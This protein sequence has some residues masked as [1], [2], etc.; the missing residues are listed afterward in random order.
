M[1]EQDLGEILRSSYDEKKFMRLA[2]DIFK[3]FEE[4]TAYLPL[5]TK[6][7]AQLEYLKQIGEVNI[8]GVRFLVTAVKFKPGEDVKSTASLQRNVVGKVIKNNGAVGSLVAYMGYGNQWK[9]ALVSLDYFIGENGKAKVSESDPKRFYYVVGQK[10]IHTP[11][12][13]LNPIV[14]PLKQASLDELK[15]TF[16]VEVLTKEFYSKISTKFHELIGGTI[17]QKGKEISIDRQIQIYDKKKNKVMEDSIIKHFGIRL[18][19][20]IIFCWFLRKQSIIPE[21]VLSSA[22]VTNDYYHK[23]LEPLFFEVMNTPNEER[24]D[25]IKKNSKLNTIPFLNGG[26][27][28]PLDVDY[29]HPN[30][31]VSIPDKWMKELF[32]ILEEYNFVVDEGSPLDQEVSVNPEM[33]GRIFENLLAEINPETSETARKSTGS[34]YT[35][36]PI[37]DYMVKQSIKYYLLSKT[38]LSEDLIDKILSDSEEEVALTKEERRVIVEA[39]YNMKVLDP[40]CGSGAFPI[41][42]LLRVVSTLRKV[43]NQNRWKELLIKDMQDEEEIQHIDTKSDDYVRKY[44]ILKRCIYGVD[45]QPMAVELSKLRS[46]LTLIIEEKD[47]DDIKPLPNLDFKF[48]CANTLIGL[49]KEKSSFGEDPEDLEELEKLRNEFFISYGKRKKEIEEKFK[50]MKQKILQKFESF[51]DTGLESRHEKL[52]R[53][54]PFL[55]KSADWFDPFWMFGVK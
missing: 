17:V 36:R 37:V 38:K 11:L 54:D 49:P 12:E 53:W 27:F 43:D 30:G 4:R 51:G 39:L 1:H 3:D 26:L 22:T 45:I 10:E 6:E 19:D 47:K 16:S 25:M 15:D 50:I 55:G 23:V 31:T 7:T 20:R 42:I 33:L 48:V 28:E 9:L 44:G 46:F 29:Y 41:G 35:P 34:Y 5:D 13:R 14:N 2:G 40:A 24:K 21:G 18:L 52:A 32:K 8:D